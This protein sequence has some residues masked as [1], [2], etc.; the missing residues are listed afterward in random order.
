MRVMHRPVGSP[1]DKNSWREV[2][3]YPHPEPL[4]S[5]A[6]E[7]TQQ[8][9]ETAEQVDEGLQLLDRLLTEM[10]STTQIC[11]DNAVVLETLEEA[12]HLICTCQERLRDSLHLIGDFETYLSD[13]IERFAELRG[14]R[15]IHWEEE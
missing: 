5:P 15:E 12:S 7:V 2:G 8:F 10:E 9:A 13:G 14:L 3:Y 4:P 11:D 1:W 6:S